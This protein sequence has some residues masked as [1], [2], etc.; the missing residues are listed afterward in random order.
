LLLLLLLL[1][2]RPMQCRHRTTVAAGC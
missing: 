2:S 1:T